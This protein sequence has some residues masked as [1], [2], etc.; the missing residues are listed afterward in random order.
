MAEEAQPLVRVYLTLADVLQTG[1]IGEALADIQGDRIL[2][3]DGSSR[4][5][6]SGEGQSWHRTRWAAENYAHQLQMQRVRELRAE[7][8]RIEALRFKGT[9]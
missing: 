2:I 6:V 9:V 1:S 5:I 8:A 4:F 3:R 7:L